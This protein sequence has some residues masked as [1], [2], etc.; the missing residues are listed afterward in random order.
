MKFRKRTVT[1]G[2][3][4]P[5]NQGTNVVL[6]GWVNAR[7]DYGSIVFIDLRDREG[8]TQVV[9]DATSKPDLAAR[10]KDVR[11]EWVLWVEGMVRMRENPNPNI[12]TGLIEVIASDAD[13]INRSNVPPFEVDDEVQ[14]NEELRLQYRYLD[15]RRPLIQ[16]RFLLRNQLY[17]STHT[18]FAREG[19]VEVETPVLT[20]STPE[21]A[22][23]YLVP[24]RVNKGRFYALPQSPQLFKQ[25]LMVAGFD[26]YMQIVKAFRDEDLRADRQPEFTQID[27][28]MSFV[29]Q[30]DVMDLT[31]RFVAAVWKE[32][33]G[34][35]LTTP[36]PRMTYRHAIDTYGSD[37]PD[38]RYDLPLYD[39]T[40]QCVHSGFALF[41]DAIANG[42]V[43]KVLRIPQCAGY[44][45]KQL[46]ELTEHAKKHGA[47][48]MP[49]LK[50][51]N[52]E[53]SGSFAKQ[54]TEGESQTL[55]S[56]IGAADNDLLLFSVGEWER[57][58]VILGA[59]RV[60]MAKRL[61]LTDAADSLYSITWVTEFP[62][63]EHDPDENRWVARHHPFTSPMVEDLHLLE[64]APQS[65]RA[66]AYDLVIN[67]Y[68]AAGGS[69]RIH[70][71]TVQ[72]RVFE[73]IGISKHEA[74]NKFGF[75]LNALQYGAPPHGG[76][77]FGFDRLVMLLAGTN[78]IRDVIAFPKTTSGLSL[79]DGCPSEVDTKQ[80]D[81]LGLCIIE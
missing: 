73:L 56:S 69:V 71:R 8:L 50:M 66:Q 3:L 34:Q 25:I 62:L 37:K 21:G 53:V 19:F 9:I 65:V 48:G 36:F 55:L 47:G 68:E 28:E 49:Y 81:E 29:D 13:V 5:E 67:G 45:R 38:L 10:L 75:L 80:L 41:R 39:V 72:Q 18:F 61:A 2:Q 77:A 46:D 57:A 54:L 12:P 40:E 14:A 1:C 79:M 63:L 76:I 44:S 35:Q 16:K 11:S 64:S 24:S 33:L 17:Q 4:R 43:V 27:V 59:L 52:G 6:N 20:R 60:E 15:L 23:D 51:M 42:G 31:E 58:S 32:V 7:R 30:S 26:K 78:N 22:R 70:D 74:E